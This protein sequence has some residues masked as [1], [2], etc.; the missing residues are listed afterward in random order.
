MLRYCWG[1]SNSNATEVFSHLISFPTF[2]VISLLL[3]SEY[4]STLFYMFK[5]R[6]LTVH[7]GSEIE[8]G[9]HALRA[10]ESFRKHI[11]DVGWLSVRVDVSFSVHVP[12]SGYLRPLF[13]QY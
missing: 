9:S 10:T 12:G 11:L 2:S 8:P 7:V 4:F 6:I 13:T 1:V 5:D 3:L